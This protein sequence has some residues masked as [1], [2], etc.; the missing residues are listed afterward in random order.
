[1]L[2]P[3][4]VQR[5][6]AKAAERTGVALTELAA[7]VAWPTITFAGELRLD[8]G[9]KHVRLFSTPGHS[10][11]SIA[12]FVEED[13]VLFGGDTVF[14][15]FVPA[16]ADGNGLTLESTL[17]GLADMDIEVLVPGHGTVLCGSEG[18][19]AWLAWL[20][21]YLVRVRASVIDGLQRGRTPAELAEA[22]S[23]QEIVGDRV[24]ADKHGM[25][26]RHGNVVTKIVEEELGR[27]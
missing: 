21:D 10:P 4:V 15:G 22:A 23:F 9:D 24:P 17:W 7:Q 16:I 26:R 2:T 25:V 27:L 8:L 1:M 18:V 6:L 13:R 20:A 11:D 12:A 19:R 3:S 5:T 14:S